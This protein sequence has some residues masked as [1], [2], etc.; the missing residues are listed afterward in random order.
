MFCAHCLDVPCIAHYA[1]HIFKW[2]GLEFKIMNKKSKTTLSI[3]ISEY[4]TFL[5]IKI[6]NVI[7]FKL[8]IKAI[9]AHKSSAKYV[10]DQKIIILQP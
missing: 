8:R 4:L 3:F 7:F 6:L 9:N 1:V 2:V 10:S 5:D